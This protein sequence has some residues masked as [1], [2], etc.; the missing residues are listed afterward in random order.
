MGFNGDV[1]V[2]RSPHALAD[3]DASVGT[4]GHPV[5]GEWTGNDGWRVVHVSHDDD[6]GEYDREWLTDIAEATGHPV[7]VCN[8]FESDVARLRGVAGALFVDGW[9]DPDAATH[10]LAGCWFQKLADEVNEDPY[11]VG[12]DFGSEQFYDTLAAEVRGALDRARPD[13]VEA[14]VAWARA[15]GY[16]VATEDVDQHLQRK[17]E[18]YVEDLF[19]ELLQ[20][21]GL[22]P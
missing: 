11:Y 5:F 12:G 14:V 19:F 2:Y 21:I 8:V 13:V 22:M 1:V 6:P 3:L 7:L 4:S 20:L 15:A 16:D 10:S 9:L 17:R 18:P